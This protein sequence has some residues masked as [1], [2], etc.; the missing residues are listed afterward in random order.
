MQS[1][2]E[3]NSPVQSFI[4]EFENDSFWTELVNRLAIRDMVRELGQEKAQAMDVRERLARRLDYEERY[5]Q[6]FQAHGL[7]RLAIKE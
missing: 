4:D 1:K 5:D 3:E 7:E 6:E 2:G